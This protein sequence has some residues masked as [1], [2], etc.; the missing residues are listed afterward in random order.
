MFTGL[1]RRVG[2]QSLQKR[3]FFSRQQ[4]ERLQEWGEQFVPLTNKNDPDPRFIQVVKKEK[5]TTGLIISTAAYIAYAYNRPLKD[6]NLFDRNGDIRLPLITPFLNYVGDRIGRTN[7][8]VHDFDPF[9]ELSDEE[10]LQRVDYLD[11]QGFFNRY[12]QDQGDNVDKLRLMNAV[13]QHA[14]FIRSN[15]AFYYPEDE[16]YTVSQVADI[17]DQQC[18]TKQPKLQYYNGS[19][20]VLVDTPVDRHAAYI[21]NS[22]I[23]DQQMAETA[24][25]ALTKQD[26]A[27]FENLYKL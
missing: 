8:L 20:L 23:K 1:F 10:K 13:T 7:V 4:G 18:S 11:A 9:E 17:Y 3:S 21:I 25:Q 2:T 24:Q 5:L 14:L 15:N 26:T 16:V 6:T 19:D 27:A 12:W 22:L